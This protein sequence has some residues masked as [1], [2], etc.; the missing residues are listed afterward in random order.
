V[1]PLPQTTGANESKNC[2]HAD[3]YLPPV[4]RIGDEL[5]QNLRKNP[6][7]KNL[8]TAGSCRLQGFDGL[9]VYVF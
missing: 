6:I 5:G 2:S 9:L 7:K 1:N 4:Q 8:E 3:I